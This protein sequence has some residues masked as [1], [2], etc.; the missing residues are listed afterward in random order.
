MILSVVMLKTK[1]FLFLRPSLTQEVSSPAAKNSLERRLAQKSQELQCLREKFKSLEQQESSLSV[2]YG[3]LKVD[4]EDRERRLKR[5]DEE[6]DMMEREMV[7]LT[8][9]MN[10]GTMNLYFSIS[11]ILYHTH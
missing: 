2:Q 1:S 10:V 4:L 11:Q 3:K 7:Q 6:R 8:S 9:E 5:S